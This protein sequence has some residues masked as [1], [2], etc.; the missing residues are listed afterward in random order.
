MN[1]EEGNAYLGEVPL[2]SFIKVPWPSVVQVR[3][4]ALESFFG[5]DGTRRD[6]IQA[7]ASLQQIEYPERFRQSTPDRA[8]Q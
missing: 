8:V 6:R 4:A 7:V 1:P 5:R 3:V 2:L